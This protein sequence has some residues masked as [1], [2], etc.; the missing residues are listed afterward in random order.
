[1]GV[2]TN[3]NCCKLVFKCTIFFLYKLYKVSFF[4]DI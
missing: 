3:L 2:D 4:T 1:M